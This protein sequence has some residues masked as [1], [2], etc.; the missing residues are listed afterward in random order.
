MNLEWLIV[1]GGIH[2]VHIAARLIGE[3]SVNSRGLRILDPGDRLLSRWH[4]CTAITGMTH[5]RSPVVHHIDL[6]PWALERFAG[7]RSERKSGLFRAPYKRPA[8]HFFNSHCEQV[9]GRF[10]LAELHIQE[11][12]D[13]CVLDERGAVVELSGG[14]QVVAENLVLAIGSGGPQNWP[15]WA[16]RNTERVFHILSLIHI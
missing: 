1:G 5:L 14:Q 8:L 12:A 11:R 7:R 2:G 13:S 10:G 4:T 9:L 15:S 16:P 6:D 3:A